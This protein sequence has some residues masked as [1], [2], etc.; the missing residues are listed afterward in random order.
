MKSSHCLR[1]W[2]FYLSLLKSHKKAQSNWIELFYDFLIKINKN[3]I[4]VNNGM[5][6]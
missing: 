5:I 2:D 6:S 4:A 3:P 1:Q